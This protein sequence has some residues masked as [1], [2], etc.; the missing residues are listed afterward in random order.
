[1]LKN[2]DFVIATIQLDDIATNSVGIIKALNGSSA[3]V[4]FI[5]AN[6]LKKVEFKNL[7]AIDIYKTGKGYDYKICNIC[8]ILKATDEFEIN[9]IDAKGLK[10]T[11]PSCRECRK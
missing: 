3:M 10:T 8:H 4:L 6:E 5:G 1:M 11:R 9:Q 2:D 7:Q